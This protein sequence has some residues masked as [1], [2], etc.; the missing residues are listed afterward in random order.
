VQAELKVDM[1]Y[2]GAILMM[3]HVS[4]R[5]RRIGAHFLH[6]AGASLC[7]AVPHWEPERRTPRHQKTGT[8]RA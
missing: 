7:A 6:K 2:I 3:L 1:H 5:Y 4:A 8:V